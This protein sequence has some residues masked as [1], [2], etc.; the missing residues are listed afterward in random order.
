MKN[1]AREKKA[2]DTHKIPDGISQKKFIK[3]QMEMF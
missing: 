3:D 2:S 1:D